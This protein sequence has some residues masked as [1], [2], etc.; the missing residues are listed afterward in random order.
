MQIANTFVVLF[1]S[2]LKGI[3]GTQRRSTQFHF[4]GNEKNE[5]VY[6][7]QAR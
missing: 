3:M 4:E 6:S 2:I 7:F 1:K 5:V